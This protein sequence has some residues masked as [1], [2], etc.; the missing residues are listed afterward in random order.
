[1]I[2]ALIARKRRPC[3]A[4]NHKSGS[5]LPAVSIRARDSRSAAA[6]ALLCG[7]MVAA[8]V[9]CG[10]SEVEP[11]PPWA[12]V[13]EGLDSALMSVWGTSES[14]V[15]AVGSDAGDGPLVMRWNGS[16]WTRM[17]T[18]SRGGLWW[19]FGF[20]GGPVFM[21]GSNGTILR[22]EDGAFTS[23]PTP[24][25][26]TVFGIWGTASDAMWAVGGSEGGG[27]R[28]FCWRLEGGEWVMAAPFPAD[29]IREKALWKVWGSAEDNVWM[30]GSGGA[31]FRWN[32]TDVESINLGGGESVFTVHEA[33]GRFA[34]V[35]GFATGFLFENDGST[36]QRK[37]D[38]NLPGLVGVSLTS[39]GGGYAVGSFGAF[40]ERKNDRWTQV[41]GPATSETLHSI[42]VDP[43]GGLWT[44]GGQ[45]QALPLV[46]GVL[47][48][49]G[50]NVP[51]GQ[52][53]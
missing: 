25:T 31:A 2:L 34:A 52:L 29:Q 3:R 36:W 48:Y 5:S 37:D 12:V 43:K 39:G 28:G 23:M 13:H 30:V 33:E 26:D 53:R 27:D 41:D 47:A 35:G 49:R 32:G 19:V 22:Y 1:M 51:E 6:L 38:S 44:V 8:Q 24:T 10:G 17:A 45:V 20:D 14:D 4:V 42:W 18:G 11:P 15:W 21:G 9:A 40:V 16:E 7:V 50:S 46:R